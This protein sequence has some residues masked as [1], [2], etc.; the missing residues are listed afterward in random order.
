MIDFSDK[1]R[2]VWQNSI[3][4][5]HRWN[6]SVGA[7]RSGKTYLDYFKIPYRI[8]NASPAGL[9]LLLGN[10]KSTLERN[11]LDPMREIWGSN[12]VGHIGSNTRVK[13]FGRDCY[14]IGADKISQ[15][16]RLQGAGLS[17]CYGDE[18]TTWHPDV[19]TMLKS[20]LD[21][22]RACFDGTCNPDNPQHWVKEFIDSDA[23]IYCMSFCIDDNPFLEPDFVS[24]L[25]LEYKGTV[26][27]DRYILG[28]WVAAE[29]LIFSVWDDAVNLVNQEA[30]P[31]SARSIAIDY[32]TINPMVFLDIRDDGENVW[33]VDEY[34]FDSKAK[35]RQKTDTQY[36]DDLVQFI[37]SDYPMNIIIDPSAA[38]F[39]AELRQRGY[40]VKDANNDVL[41][42]IRITATAI[43]LGLVRV[44]E[45]CKHTR[46]ELA[47]YVWD[48]KV[49]EKGKEQPI[50]ANDHCM[51]ALRY[52]CHTKIKPWR[53]N[54][55]GAQT[56]K[57]GSN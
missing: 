2:K 16:A 44:H 3:L 39:R 7:T 14:A 25:K 23:D 54:A 30:P 53:L 1:Q 43:G 29:G 34:Y 38:S 12:L 33:V 26:Y 13:L 9:I 49:S 56:H 22:P 36:A 41:D 50:K 10:T 47:S 4:D 18:V 24:N 6:F 21:K 19:F 52:F 20:R 37:G 51:D 57:T 5:Y 32:G 48:E 11:I 15:V 27:Y 17:Y 8:R 42:G 55:Y 35:G 40:S 46:K 28:N 45:R 31:E